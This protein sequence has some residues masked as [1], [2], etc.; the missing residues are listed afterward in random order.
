MRH[1]GL[2]PVEIK[3]RTTF[4]GRGIEK[5]LQFLAHHL[6]DKHETPKLEL[7]PIEVLLPAFLGASVRP[8]LALKWIEPQVDQVRHVNVR[9]FPEP[10]AGLIDE[11]IFVVVNAY[12][13]DRA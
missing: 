10:A 9:L 2:H 12:R 3:A 8:T 13:A 4:P 6:L 5:G 1:L 7:E 11:A